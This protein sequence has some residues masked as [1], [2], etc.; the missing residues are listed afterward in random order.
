[1]N[2]CKRTAKQGIVPLCQEISKIVSHNHQLATRAR[3]FEEKY[4]MAAEKLKNS[5]PMQKMK[6]FVCQTIQEISIQTTYIA[7]YETTG[8]NTNLVGEVKC[9]CKH[10]QPIP[11][12][13]QGT[14]V[15]INYI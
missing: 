6:D 8:T 10:C 12:N 7:N 2:S 3:N 4:E 13:E 5:K 14:Q 9:L 15:I 11:Q 1:M